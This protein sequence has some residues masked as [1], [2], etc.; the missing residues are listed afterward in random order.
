MMTII[1]YIVIGIIV[2]VLASVLLP[3]IL[4]GGIGYAIYRY[5]DNIS[6]WFGGIKH[7][8]WKIIGLVFAGIILLGLIIQWFEK[9]KYTKIIAFINE[10]GM[11]EVDE[12][13]QNIGMSNVEIYKG[14][15]V[16]MRYGD[17]TKIEIQN[18]ETKE[19][20]TCYRSKYGMGKNLEVSRE[21]SLD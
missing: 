20:I 15:E 1:L 5:W 7:W 19:N 11:C 18:P 21:I 2:L 8:N 13:I 14:L 16:F 12:I 9:S 3:Y 10:M 4:V 6:G 17:I